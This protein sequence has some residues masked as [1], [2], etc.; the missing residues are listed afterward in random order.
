MY[1]KIFKSI[2]L[3]TIAFYSSLF[4]LSGCGKAEKVNPYLSDSFSTVKWPDSA[5]AKLLPV[6]ESTSGMIDTDRAD[7]LEI[8]IGSTTQEQYESYVGSCKAKGFTENYESGTDYKN[9]PYYRAENSEGYRL[10]LEYHK[11]DEADDY[12][13]MK[14]T[15]TIE[16]QT[17]QKEE[18]EA[19]TEK[20]TEKPTEAPK[21]PENKPESK[22]IADAGV[23]TP[24][25]KE[26]MDSYEAF[27]DSYIE[28]MK[29]YKENPGDLTMISEYADYMS[30]YT[31]YMSKLTAI[32]TTT[33][34]VADLAYY[35]EVHSRILKKM[36]GTGE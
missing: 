13:P 28:F 36:A 10:S 25:F 4:S 22:S 32:D 24:S 9:C 2:V 27:F 12:H 17:P 7:R 11:E 3:S 23:V 21:E 33:L 1:M 15:M 20:P 18:T 19:E 31:D 14:D 26:T 16:L 5:L 35:N 8:Y 34:S 29:K 6:P 30:K